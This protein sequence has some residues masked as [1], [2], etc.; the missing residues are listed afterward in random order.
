MTT[1]VRCAWPTSARC[2]PPQTFGNEDEAVTLANST[3]YGLAATVFTGDKDRAERI[4]PQLVLAPVP[5][6]MLRCD[7]RLELNNGKEISL[8]PGLERL[9]TEVF[10]VLDLG[11]ALATIPP[12]IAAGFGTFCVMPS[13]LSDDPA[14]M[15]RLCREIMRRVDGLL[16]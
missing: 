16:P 10:E 5:T 6:I 14:G 3:P 7:E 2:C 13:Q 4:S 12:Q 8:V 9:R 15:G 11:Q 1:L